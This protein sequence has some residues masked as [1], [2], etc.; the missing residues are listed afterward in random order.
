MS[1]FAT[2]LDPSTAVRA[3][4]G[5]VFLYACSLLALWGRC[6]GMRYM[7]HAFPALHLAALV[8]HAVLLHALIDR[9]GIQNL[10]AAHL[11]S[12]LCWTLG[13]SLCLMARRRYMVVWQVAIAPLAMASI[14][15]AAV[16]HGHAWVHAGAR[17]VVLWHILLAVGMVNVLTLAALTA[18]MIL[19]QERRIRRHAFQGMGQHLPALALLERHLFQWLWAGFGLLT[20]MLVLS[21]YQYRW[22]L[23]STPHWRFKLWVAI[24]AWGMFALALAGRLAY[25]SRGSRVVVATLAG[26]LLLWVIYIG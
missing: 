4:I 11:F 5:A 3:S 12:L 22:L 20:G 18:L 24:A 17:P 9:G 16:S 1:L 10:S 21:A 19:W 15:W 6:R 23:W 2:M 7:G 25:G 13:V 26:V 8:L 14:A